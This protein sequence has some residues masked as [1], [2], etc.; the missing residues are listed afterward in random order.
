[1]TFQIRDFAAQ[2]LQDLHSRQ[3]QKM[4]NTMRPKKT[5]HVK[6]SSSQNG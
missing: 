3:H 2:G 6:I 5:F 1:M 4:N